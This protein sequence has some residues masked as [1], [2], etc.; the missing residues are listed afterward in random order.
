[1]R[2]A[3]KLKCLAHFWC[4]VTSKAQIFWL[5]AKFLLGTKGRPKSDK[6]YVIY[7]TQTDI[8]NNKASIP[9]QGK[10]A[11]AFSNLGPTYLRHCL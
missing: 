10:Y 1:M 11:Q 8:L 5:Q 9:Y 6:T 3:G 4:L 2:S 7:D